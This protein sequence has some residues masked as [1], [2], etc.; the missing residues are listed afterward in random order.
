MVPD[1]SLAHFVTI[2]WL[3]DGVD[4]GRIP[5]PAAITPPDEA[6]ADLRLSFRQEAAALDLDAAKCVPVRSGDVWSLEPGQRIVMRAPSGSVRVLPAE[7]GVFKTTPFR[8]VTVAGANV[9]AVRPVKF[10][11][12]VDVPDVPVAQVCADRAI[13][14][15]A[16]AA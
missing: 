3:L 10:R 11:L 8:I 13:V 9:V 16:Q 12:T 2:G 14:D 4:A 5:K 15:A 1:Q 6:M 7:E